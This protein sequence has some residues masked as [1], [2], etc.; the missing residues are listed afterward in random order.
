M[1]ESTGIPRKTIIKIIQQL[2]ENSR[3]KAKYDPI[4]QGIELQYLQTEINQL[5][6]QFDEWEHL[7][8]GK[9]QSLIE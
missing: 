7:G 1:E 4:S 9:K 6:E 2:I 5:F 3:I 8:V